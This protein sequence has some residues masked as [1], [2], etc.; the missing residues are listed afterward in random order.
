MIKTLSNI[1]L[2]MTRFSKLRN[3]FLV[4]VS[5]GSGFRNLGF[6]VWKFYGEMGLRQ[7]EQGLSLFFA[8]FLAYLMIF[9]SRERM[10]RMKTSL[11]QLALN[12]FLHSTSK[13]QN[14]GFGYPKIR[15]WFSN[16]SLVVVMSKKLKQ[17]H[18]MKTMPA[19]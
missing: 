13:T 10:C 16:P 5:D 17:K 2:T 9:E 12:P 4:I 1:T 8:I 11:V 7:V 15:F 14:S 19:Y 6:G 18:L 3:V